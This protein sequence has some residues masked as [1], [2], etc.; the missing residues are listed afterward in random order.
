MCQIDCLILVKAL[1]QM[2]FYRWQQRRYIGNLFFAFMLATQVSSFKSRAL[3]S[4][5]ILSLH[6]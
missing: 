5:K 6:L 3:E 4:D 1:F 2:H